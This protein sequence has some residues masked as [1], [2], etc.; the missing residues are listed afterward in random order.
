MKNMRPFKDAW[1]IFL[2][3]T[4]VAGIA[5]Q[6]IGTAPSVVGPAALTVVNVIPNSTPLVPII[7]TSSAI[8]YFDNAATIGYGYS[9]EYSPPGGSDTIYVVQQ[10]SD[11]ASL[12]PK[13]K[14]LM[15]YDILQLKIGG[16]YSLF[17]TGSDTSSPDYLFTIDSLPYHGPTDSTVGIRFVNLSTDSN[18]IS[19]N[20]EG[21]PNGSE[22]GSL[23]YKGITVFKDY[24]SNA[25]A[26]ANGYLFVFRD[27]LT[28]DSLTSFPLMDYN[29]PI[30]G[31][32]DPNTYNQITFKNVTLAFFGSTNPTSNQPA[33]VML[34]E[35]Y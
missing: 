9:L 26:S 10:N 4:L 5:C 12:G 23:T 25:T 14:G 17:L 31:L 30:P 22:V 28:G 2:L 27:A 35:D 3:I 1:E 29:S 20:L 34:V 11:T 32:T 33:S 24:L 21:D 18:P 7:N 16:I 15:F 13:A 8:T 19:V 6:K